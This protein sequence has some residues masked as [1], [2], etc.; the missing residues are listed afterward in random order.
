MSRFLNLFYALIVVLGI[1]H[2]VNGFSS[3]SMGR[4]IHDKS[5][6]LFMAATIDAPQQT[7]T[8]DDDVTEKGLLKRDRYVATNR[9]AVR[10]GQQAKFEKRWATRK[11]RLA[12]LPGFQYF[13]LMRRAV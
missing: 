1:T 3:S 4:S 5:S 9:F 6:T 2:F 8:S 11:S 13:H 7:T 12:T 10:K